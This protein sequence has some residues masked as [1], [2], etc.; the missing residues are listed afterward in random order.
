MQHALRMHAHFNQFRVKSNIQ[1]SFDKFEPLFICVAE[2]TVI[3]APIDQFGWCRASARG[4][5]P[6]VV[7]GFSP[8]RP[9]YAVRMSLEQEHLLISSGLENG[10]VLAVYR[11]NFDP[12]FCRAVSN[13]VFR[14]NQR[15]LMARARACP[16]LAP[17]A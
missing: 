17:Q 1:H 16:R 14:R 10:A 3:F 6:P 8:K 15:I 5:S 9:P 11:Q 2:S 4:S 12:V 13:T 7:Q